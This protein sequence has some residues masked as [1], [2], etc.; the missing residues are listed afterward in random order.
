MTEQGANANEIEQKKVGGK[1]NVMKT[2]CSV[3]KRKINQ[4]L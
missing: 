1:T 4:R 3:G 2:S